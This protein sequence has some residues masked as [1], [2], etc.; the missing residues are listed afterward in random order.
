LFIIIIIVINNLR[1]NFVRS[2]CYE[3]AYVA[4][5]N[6]KTAARVDSKLAS[7]GLRTADRDQQDSKLRQTQAANTTQHTS[8]EPFTAQ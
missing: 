2:L 3:E 7:L 8:Q 1:A 6:D 5:L 4:L